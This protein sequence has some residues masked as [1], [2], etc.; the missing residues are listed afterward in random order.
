MRCILVANNAH[1][2][3]DPKMGGVGIQVVW[4]VGVSGMAL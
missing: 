2:K 3:H 1:S 4:D